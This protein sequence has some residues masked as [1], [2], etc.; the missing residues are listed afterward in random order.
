MEIIL[1]VI[2]LL[3][4]VFLIL[5]TVV[6]VKIKRQTSAIHFNSNLETEGEKMIRYFGVDN[7]HKFVESG[8]YSYDPKTKEIT[9]KSRNKNQFLSTVTIF[10]EVGHFLTEKPYDWLILKGTAINRLVIL[11]LFILNIIFIKYVRGFYSLEILF[12]CFMLLS[13]YRLFLGMYWEYR[14]SKKA[15]LYISLY[16][17]DQKLSAMAKKYFRIDFFL[18]LLICLFIAAFNSM[19]FVIYK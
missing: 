15:S 14:A 12:T 3:I 13:F 16:F 8:I 11:P 18:Q 1:F 19:L 7:Y 2:L 4:T 10:H 17:K 6:Y 9:Y 5:I